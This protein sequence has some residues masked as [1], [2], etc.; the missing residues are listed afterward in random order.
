[1][2]ASI[3]FTNQIPQ[4]KQKAALYEFSSQICTFNALRNF[5]VPLCAIVPNEST[6]SCLVIPIPE[7]LDKKKRNEKK[8]G[9]DVQFQ[10]PL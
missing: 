1:M 4:I 10:P 3:V 2:I 9:P 7:S 5:A 8:L 6:S